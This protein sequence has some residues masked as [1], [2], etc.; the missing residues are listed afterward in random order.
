MVRPARVYVPLKDRG[1]LIWSSNPQCLPYTR[2]IPIYQALGGLCLR[3]QYP[4]VAIPARSGS[5]RPAK[6]AIVK[7]PQAI[8]TMTA[9]NRNAALPD[10]GL[11]FSTLLIPCFDEMALLLC[12]S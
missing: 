4:D 11:S 12:A 10:R 2:K 5:S 6:N 9:T 8:M 7:I 3:R 1:G